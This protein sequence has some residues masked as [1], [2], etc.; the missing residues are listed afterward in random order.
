M[1]NI[2][3][4]I[5]LKVENLI[6]DLGYEVYYIEYVNELGYNFLRVILKHKQEGKKITT[7]DCEIVT[8]TINP[9]IDEINIEEQFFLEVSSPG[10]NRKLY[11][12]EHMQGSIGKL[13]LV[14]SRKSIENSKKNIGI[15]HKVNGDMITLEIKGKKIEINIE[16]IKTISLEE[17]SQEDIHE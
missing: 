15:L 17:I 5:R 12:V 4:L 14:K 3:K 16:D 13:V 1:N 9:I 6:N 2:S 8:K 11:T 10:I 7:Y